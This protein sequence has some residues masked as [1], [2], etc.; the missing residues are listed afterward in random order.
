MSKDLVDILQEKKQ[1][2]EELCKKR[3]SKKKLIVDTTKELR[4]LEKQ[5]DAKTTEYCKA[6]KDV[7]GS[8]CPQPPC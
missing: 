7:F 1:H 5:I 4:D 2:I 3:T 6:F 8:E